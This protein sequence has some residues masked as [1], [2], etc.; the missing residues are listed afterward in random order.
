MNRDVL[1]SLA[2]KAGFSELMS[3]PQFVDILSRYTNLLQ[4]RMQKEDT[5]IPKYKVCIEFKGMTSAGVIKVRKD[6]DSK[7]F[8]TMPVHMLTE[9]FGLA[10]VEFRAQLDNPN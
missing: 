3:Q 2:R 1:H 9:H 10:A 6:I 5:S 7:T 4:Q 8:Q